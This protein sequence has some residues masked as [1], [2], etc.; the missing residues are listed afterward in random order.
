M[1]VRRLVPWLVSL[2]MALVVAAPTVAFTGFGASRATATYGDDMTFSVALPGGAPERLDLLLRF[3]ASEVTLVVPVQPQATSADYRW[4]AADRPITPN[5]PIHYRWRATQAGSATLGPEQTVLYDDDRPGL[6]WQTAR[7]GEATVHWYGSAEAEA[8][9][10]GE[11]TAG[12]VARAEDLLGHALSGPID[13]FVYETRDDFFGALGAG[14]REWTGAAA[15]PELR[16]VFMWLGGGSDAYLETA[17][18]HEVTHIVFNDATSNPFHEPPS[19]FNEGLA[20]WSELGSAAAEQATVEAEAS[21]GLFAF[22]AIQSAFPIDG[23]GAR[24]AY[25]QGATMLEMIIDEHGPEAIAAIAG[26]WRDGATDAEALEA[27]TGLT[28]NAL[29]QAYFARYGADVPRPVEPAPID[30]SEVS[31]PRNGGGPLE[32]GPSPS[33]GSAGGAS[34]GDWLPL[35]IGAVALL[36]ILGVLVGARLGRSRVSG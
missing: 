9:H 2:A 12:G 23:R 21:A 5:T 15:F 7:L 8:R 16:T 19:W 33:S 22:E 6:D 20:S 28:W 31:L 26:A 3:G 36:T 30:R 1:R 11:L 10:F 4:D 24:L 18:V 14:A 17:L 29:Q 27:G 32:P 13:I 34:S 35:A 25:A